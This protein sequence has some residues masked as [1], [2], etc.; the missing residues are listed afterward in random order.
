MVLKKAVVRK[1]LKSKALKETAK[2]GVKLVLTEKF[3]SK[4]KTLRIIVRHL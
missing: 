3:L 2:F 1:V 4:H